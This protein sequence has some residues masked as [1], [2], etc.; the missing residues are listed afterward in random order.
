[1]SSIVTQGFGIKNTGIVTQ[2]YGL[3]IEKIIIDV[4]DGFTKRKPGGSSSS[5]R[6]YTE[7]EKEYEEYHI[8]AA[9]ISSNDQDLSIPI[10]NEIRKRIESSNINVEIKDIS[11]SF[12]KQKIE[13]KAT[14]KTIK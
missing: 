2:G 9:L 4:I 13:V 1:M 6:R 5:K 12:R 14:I 11:V 3:N 10:S 7:N 8:S